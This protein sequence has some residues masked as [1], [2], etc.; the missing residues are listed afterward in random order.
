MGFKFCPR[1]EALPVKSREVSKL[2]TTR[3]TLTTSDWAV[4]ILTVTP[5]I[6]TSLREMHQ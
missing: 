4:L 6:N 5:K 1:T 3:V 2:L